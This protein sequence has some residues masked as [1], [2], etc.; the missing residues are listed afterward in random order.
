MN[1]MAEINNKYQQYYQAA[2]LWAKARAALGSASE[3][4]ITRALALYYALQDE[5]TPKWAKGVI[6]GALGY[7]ILPLDAVADMLP[8]VGLADDAAVLAAAAAT[9]MAH[10]KQLH[11]MK[12]RAV[13]DAWLGR[14]KECI[15]V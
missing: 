1:M 7:F 10:V 6:V 8:F 5:D 9:V 4:V 11:M 14:N 2:A 15:E 3:A 13:L 12:A